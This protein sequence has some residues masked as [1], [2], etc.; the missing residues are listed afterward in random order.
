[1]RIDKCLL[2]KP[3]P[4]S[5]QPLF[6]ASYPTSTTLTLRR[7][8]FAA[9][10]IFMRC[11]SKNAYGVPFSAGYE[12]KKKETIGRVSYQHSPCATKIDALH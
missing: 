9:L 4:K 3:P 1:M 7:G 5:P 11:A 2:L 12:Q 10:A 6:H 8:K